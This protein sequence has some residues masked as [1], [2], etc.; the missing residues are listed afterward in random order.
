MVPWAPMPT[1]EDELEQDVV[2][3]IR[4]YT[5][6]CWKCAGAGQGPDIGA[7]RETLTL[8][9]G[10]TAFVYPNVGC[11][12]CEGSGVI[13]AKWTDPTVLATVMSGVVGTA[14]RCRKN[15]DFD[16]M[17]RALDWG[18]AFSMRGI[19]QTGLSVSEALAL[20]AELIQNSPIDDIKPVV[21][22]AGTGLSRAELIELGVVEPDEPIDAEPL[23]AKQL[24]AIAE[25]FD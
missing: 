7:R 23:T 8:E 21:R 3:A 22:A 6:T 18:V 20:T 11:E 16:G 4:M 13:I 1:I 9:D 19:A 14:V 17:N 15:S 2:K 5:R 24:D 25:T 12:P 10:R